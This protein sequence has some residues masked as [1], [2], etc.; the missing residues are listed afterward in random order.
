MIVKRLCFC[1]AEFVEIY[2]LFLFS[3]Q[4][5]FAVK[6]MSAAVWMWLLIVNIQWMKLLILLCI[7]VKKSNNKH[8]NFND[9]YIF[10]V[11]IGG[12]S[13]RGKGGDLIVWWGIWGIVDLIYLLIAFRL[14]PWRERS[15]IININEKIHWFCIEIFVKI[16]IGDLV[17]LLNLLNILVSIRIGRYVNYYFILLWLGNCLY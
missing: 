7:I 9:M 14:S 6:T 8:R 16:V 17:W 11:L 5:Y 15:I 10:Q 1:I 3:F 13:T 4:F 2:S 12:S